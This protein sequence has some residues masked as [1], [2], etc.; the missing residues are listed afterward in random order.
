ME[1]C[2]HYWSYD[3]TI[4]SGK[5]DKACVRRWCGECGLIQSAKVDKWRKS[6]VGPTKEFSD[7]PKGYPHKFRTGGIDT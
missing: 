7:Y 3:H 5:D 4:Y 6:T 1:K 2:D